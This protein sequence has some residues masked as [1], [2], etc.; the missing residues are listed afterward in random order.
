MQGLVLCIGYVYFWIWLFKLAIAKWHKIKYNYRSQMEYTVPE[1]FLNMMGWEQA[2]PNCLICRSYL[3]YVNNQRSL[4]TF[5]IFVW[6]NEVNHFASF[7]FSVIELWAMQP[8]LVIYFT[9]ITSVYC[10]EPICGLIKCSLYLI[11][12][13]YLGSA[14]GYCTA[15]FYSG[16][17]LAFVLLCM[18]VVF[19]FPHLNGLACY[20]TLKEGRKYGEWKLRQYSVSVRDPPG[21]ILS[22]VTLSLWT[23]VVWFG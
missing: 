5:C 3:V 21:E 22:H 16:S 23:S 10:N 6:Q 1:C 17:P 18:L 13:G 2:N 20:R 9:L 14:E 8:R 15:V 7:C 11:L 19:V 12:P 4:C